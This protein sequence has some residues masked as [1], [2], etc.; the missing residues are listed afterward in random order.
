M[1]PVYALL[2]FVIALLAT[3][4]LCH[5]GARLRI[6]DYP[7]ERSLH[8]RPTPRTGGLAILAA[9]CGV[10]VPLAL[11]WPTITMGIIAGGGLSIAMLSFLDDRFSISPALRMLAHVVVA[12][13]LLA[14][15]LGPSG[16]SLPGMYLAW[17]VA[18][19]APLSV[20]FVVWM[21]NLYN[22]MDGMDGLAGGMTMIGFSSFA[23]LGMIAGNAPFATLSLAA[24]AA[25]GGF[26]VFNFPPARIFMGD[27]GSSL[28]GFLAA[29]LAVW[30]ERDGIVPMW[31]TLLI[32][33]PFI[34]DASATLLQ[35]AWRG[36]TL[37][38]AHKRHYYQRLVQLGWGHK[39]TVLY[40]YALMF[41]CAVSALW[42]TRQTP[43]VQW[44][45][46][47]LWAVCYPM[48]MVGVTRLERAGQSE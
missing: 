12:I 8:T 13:L 11:A 14:G 32:F 44:F 18:I 3:R 36:E 10:T 35:R 17:P 23:L 16:L 45:I 26:L 6:L 19:G 46:L 25:A 43:S 27:A 37:W 2:A 42:A 22:F 41:A 5:P 20:L 31:A 15:G 40:E 9:I 7:N 4:Y 47:A 34:V 39:K 33:S 48:L 38:Q 21:I 1:T 28:L 30:G 24:A 29:A